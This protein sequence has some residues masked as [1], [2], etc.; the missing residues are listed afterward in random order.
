MSTTE[1][2]RTAFD[3]PMNSPSEPKISAEIGMMPMNAMTNSAMTRPRSCGGAEAW[4]DV[5]V[6]ELVVMSAAPANA[7]T[8]A[9][10]S[11]SCA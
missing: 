6:S 2:T 10:D 1:P 3:G 11:H 4:I 7:E 9:I 5:F 8:A